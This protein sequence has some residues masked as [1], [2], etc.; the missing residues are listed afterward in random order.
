MAWLLSEPRAHAVRLFTSSKIFP[1]NML[2]VETVSSIMF[3]VSCVTVLNNIRNIF[4]KANEK[5]HET[6][7]S[8]S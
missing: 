4:I 6:M 7:F 5:H 2:Y 1:L 8:S 3:D